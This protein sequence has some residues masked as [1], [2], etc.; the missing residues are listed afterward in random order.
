MPAEILWRQGNLVKVRDRRTKK[1][2][3]G[4]VKTLGGKKLRCSVFATRKEAEQALNALIFRFHMEKIT[5]HVAPPTPATYKELVD[6]YLQDARDRGVTAGV[7]ANTRRVLDR[8]GDLL[9][10]EAETKL[11]DITAEDLRN[12][13]SGRLAVEPPLHPHTITFE[14]KRIRTVFLAARSLLEISWDPP[15]ISGIKAVHQ[16][17]ETTL[18]H[19]Q[20]AELLNRASGPIADFILLG[21]HTAMRAGE[22]LSLT[23]RKVDFT[24]GVDSPYGRLRF[25]S[26]KGKREASLPLTA[27]AAAVLAKRLGK[28]GRPDDAVFE[29]GYHKIR[30]AFIDACAAAG[31][32]YG[33]EEG[34]TVIH[35]LRHSAAS[36]LANLGV[37]VHI[38]KMITRHSSSHAL[39]KYTHAGSREIGEAMGRL[40]EIGGEQ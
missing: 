16:G 2:R 39:M 32:S 27:Q 19:G 36:Y 31:V 6:L 11:V 10:A 17:R 22:I 30:R 20:I 4:Y 35:T 33:R 7:I 12:Y 18:S 38:L 9:P 5:G 1:E 26:E 29:E 8:F 37:P 3:W 15:K 24:A 14:L 40:G 23:R 13:R 28:S 21:L 25:I 34:G